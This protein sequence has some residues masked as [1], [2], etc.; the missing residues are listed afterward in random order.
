M[1]FFDAFLLRNE[2]ILLH[3]TFDRMEQA[4]ETPFPNPDLITTADTTGSR[5][6]ASETA[7]E[8]EQSEATPPRPL[9]ERDREPA[10][11]PKAGFQRETHNKRE[12]I[13]D[14]NTNQPAPPLPPP[15]QIRPP[16]ETMTSFPARRPRFRE[17][18]N[19]GSRRSLG[20]HRRTRRQAIAL[21]AFL[22]MLLFVVLSSAFWI[23]A[24]LILRQQPS[25]KEE[26]ISP[27]SERSAQTATPLR[28]SPPVPSQESTPTVIEVPAVLPLPPPANRSPGPRATE[29]PAKSSDYPSNK[30][31]ANAS[32][33]ISAQSESPGEILRLDTDAFTLTVERPAAQNATISPPPDRQRMI[34]GDEITHRVVSGDTLWD[35]A[36]HYLGDP[37]QYPELARLSQIRDPDL[38]YPG[39]L[40]RIR[41][42]AAAQETRRNDDGPI[43]SDDK[44]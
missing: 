35:I 32:G 22:V 7:P 2:Q 28:A 13:P 11:D 9:P 36:S 38:I 41:M 16:R 33:R 23:K 15:M 43:D 25:H 6:K 42:K 5:V 14:A 37:F 17:T 24:R 27:G 20:D 19:A 1:D 44:R 18:R 30:V 39:D 8:A 4:R 21:T 29:M 31:A 10:T 34:P 26:T 3:T 40:V 12:G